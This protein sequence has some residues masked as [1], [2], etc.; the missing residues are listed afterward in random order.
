MYTEMDRLL[1]ELA[2]GQHNVFTLHQAAAIG[3]TERQAMRRVAS[4]A[5]PRLGPGVYA[6]PGAN[7]DHRA[8]IHALAMATVG[9]VVSH[10]S[11]GE[12]RDYPLVRR[13]LV[14]VSR[15]HARPNRTELG[16]IRRVGDFRPSDHDVIDGIPVTSALRTA[17]DLAAVMRTER[18]RRMIDALLVRKEFTPAELTTM[19]LRWCRRG[20]KGSRLLWETVDARG[21]G[22]VAPESVLEE[23]GLALLADGGFPPPVRQL[24]LPWRDDLPGRVDCAYV[25][26]RVLIE[27]D[28]R[29]HHLIEEQFETDRIRD[30]EAISHGWL[31]LR[32]TWKMIHHQQEWVWTKV[33]QTL[34]IGARNSANSAHSPT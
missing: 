26:E 11:A 7:L 28:S 13:G 25:V 14:V 16:R 1:T 34:A 32:V 3:F 29:K 21:E 8:R 12:L 17:A 18:Y 20:R 10:E 24:A 22:Y 15:P 6:L 30:A 31:P 27:W 9:S 23:E 5:W 33:R 19:A 2:G 4:G